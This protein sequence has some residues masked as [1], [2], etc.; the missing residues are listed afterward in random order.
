MSENTAPSLKK[1]IA[2]DPSFVSQKDDRGWTFLHQEAL[3]GN[4]ATVK[5]LLDAGADVNARTGHGMTP[6]Q[7]AKSLGWDKVAALLASKGAK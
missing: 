7:L 6:L 1:E 5:V 3:A 4:M 2:N